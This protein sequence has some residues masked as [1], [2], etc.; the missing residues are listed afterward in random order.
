MSKTVEVE[1]SAV[2]REVDMFDKKKG[3]M[4][5]VGKIKS[6]KKKNEGDEAGH[7][8]KKEKHGDEDNAHADA[9]TK[10]SGRKAS[11]DHGDASKGTGRKH[12][13]DHGNSN[14]KGAGQ[15]HS[16][17]DGESN[18]VN[19]NQP[20]D[21]ADNKKKIEDVLSELDSEDEVESAQ[22]PGDDDSHFR[23][24]EIIPEDETPKAVQMKEE[25]KKVL[26]SVKNVEDR[27]KSREQVNLTM[28]SIEL[29][30]LPNA[31]R[32]TKNSPWMKGAYGTSY[33]WVAEYEESEDGS[34][35]IW[36]NL[37]WS[38]NLERNEKDRNDLVITVCSK[39]LIIG[40][41]VLGKEE[42]ADIPD[43]KTGYFEVSGDV[44]SGIGPAGK[45]KVLF[46]KGKAE[47]PHGPMKSI[48]SADSV[49]AG[50]SVSALKQA[51]I[52]QRKLYVKI[53]ST[54]VMD[55]KSVH[56][57][58]VNCPF[59]AVEVGDWVGVSDTA[60]N[61][62]MA[63]RW[64]SLNWKFTVTSDVGIHLMI[65]SKNVMIGRMHVSME[66]ISNTEPKAN[67]IIEVIKSITDGKDVTGRVKINL[68]AESPLPGDSYNPDVSLL[69]GGVKTVDE[70]GNVIEDPE[71]IAT[72]SVSALGTYP[73]AGDLAP[74]KPFMRVPFQINVREVT[75]LDTVNMHY[76][77]KNSLSVNVVCGAWGKATQELKASG[78]FAHWIDLKWK[79]PVKGTNNLR[80]TA[81]SHGVS[82][83]SANITV[84]ELLD[85]PTDYE[86]NTEIFAKLI[87]VSGDIV[88]KVKLSCKY[89]SLISVVN[90]KIVAIASSKD[91]EI[92]DF[93][94]NVGLE[95]STRSVNFMDDENPDFDFDGVSANNVQ[96]RRQELTLPL[97]ATIKSISIYDAI[98]A[99]TFVR[100]TPQIRFICDRKSATTSPI[101][102]AGSVA[103]WSDL[104]WIMKIREDSHVVAVLVS[105]E[106]TIGK[107][108]LKP[109]DLLSIP[110]NDAGL[111][112]VRITLLDS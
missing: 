7:K 97:V 39:N 84:A 48:T 103:H 63:A 52:Q 37:R 57:L 13:K 75:L 91:K 5:T 77:R 38:F 92:K 59:V 71:G 31:H 101:K 47:R 46:L 61:A 108:E 100:N 2:V 82:I 110:L 93:L 9:V 1:N 23:F 70:D 18:G 22:E 14:G 25:N 111:T 62:G 28:M 29:A 81:W 8:N 12:S 45:I 67:N 66:E 89:E 42:F 24:A 33:S 3:V 87:N 16:K 99:H 96:R 58:D 26:E 15:K 112:E 72:G 106:V 68:L 65:H 76:L 78:S 41:Y 44:M 80:I 105:G 20:K 4:E 30:T 104:N 43:T 60:H 88:G 32:F 40:R 35:A 73:G 85:M 90:E 94:P 79:I 102:N 83:G 51:V 10:K 98:S 6:K 27:L 107:V 21:H 109:K 36:K 53:I 54:A 95:K 17:E 49:T 50:A 11:K 55:L 19:G 64:N 69:D 86:Q 74:L 34:K 56:F